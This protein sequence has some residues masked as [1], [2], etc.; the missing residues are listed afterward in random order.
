MVTTDHP[1]SLECAA[2]ESRPREKEVHMSY[3]ILPF[4]VAGAL[5]AALVGSAGLGCQAG[6]VGIGGSGATEGTGVVSS[7]GAGLPSRENW[8]RSAACTQIGRAHV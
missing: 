7:T 3:R 5:A 8:L 1:A 4:A 6:V 2:L